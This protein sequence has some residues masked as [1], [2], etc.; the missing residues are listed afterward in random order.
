MSVAAAADI[1]IALQQVADGVAARGLKWSTDWLVE[2]LRPRAE[3]VRALAT[4]DRGPVH[5]VEVAAAVE[6]LSRPDAIMIGDGADIQNWAYG[7]MRAKTNPAFL[8]HYP[9]GSMGVGMP[10]AVGAA[11]AAREQAG[12]DRPRPVVMVTGDGSFG[13]YPAELQSAAQAGLNLT[14]VIAN[15]A[16]WGTELHGQRRRAGR[17][18]QHPARAQ[19]L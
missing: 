7:V 15:D 13:F 4:R 18:L 12:D 14:V 10:M 8:E 6:E 5:P 3:A 17:R 1:G 9:L 2:S 19:P 11:A 16:A